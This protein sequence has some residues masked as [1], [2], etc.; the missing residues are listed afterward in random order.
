MVDKFIKIL[1][2][3]AKIYQIDKILEQRAQTETSL[4]K[5]ALTKKI[6]KR[7]N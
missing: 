1:N 4:K 6:S 7:P 3:K 5:N 2:A